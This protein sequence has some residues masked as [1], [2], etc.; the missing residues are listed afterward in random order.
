MKNHYKRFLYLVYILLAI[1]LITRG[2]ILFLHIKSEAVVPSAIG[3]FD[4]QLGW[5]LKPLSIGYS[6]A[7]GKKIEY[8]INSKGLRSKEVGY[9]KPKNTFRIVLLGDSRTF[10]F[11]CSFDKIFP[12][13]LEG[14]FKDTEVINM[15]VSGYGLDQ[16]LL[17]LKLE[18]LKYHPDLILVYVAHYRSER[19]IRKKVFGRSKPCFILKDN[20][21][22]LVSFPVKAELPSF[23]RKIDAYLSIYLKSYYYFIKMPVR[24]IYDA[25]NKN[26][27]FSSKSE[28]LL[29]LGGKIVEEMD[30]IARNNAAKFAV[31]TQID[32]L[33]QR[34]KEKGVIALKLSHL[35]YKRKYA[36]P[37]GLN[38]LNDEGNAVLAKEIVQFIKEK[39]L[40]PRIYW[41]MQG[42]RYR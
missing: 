4:S 23:L 13:L 16:E 10:G 9:D 1:E 28:E 33:E 36:L 5:S 40:V 25:V 11:G 34:V 14:Y 12:S 20:K 7:T 31:I 30:M 37:H 2:L 3:Q 21:L 26:A 38:H 24:A 18:G 35:L 41:N 27:A 39:E 19:H 17:M 32:D 8:K 42:E 15:G 6:S 22:E 29:V